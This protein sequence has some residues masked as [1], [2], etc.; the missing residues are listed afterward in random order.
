MTVRAARRQFLKKAVLNQNKVVIHAEARQPEDGVFK[1][2]QAGLC[3]GVI[4]RI[5]GK[6]EDEVD[7][8]LS[9]KTMKTKRM[10]PTYGLERVYIRVEGQEYNCILKNIM[11]NPIKNFIQQVELVEYQAGHPNRV[12]VPVMLTHL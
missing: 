4:R 6:K 12:S 10:S 3:P 1:L 2:K 7:I 5:S 11:V 8:I 9:G